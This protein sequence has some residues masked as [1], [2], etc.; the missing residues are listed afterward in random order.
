MSSF[1]Y[2]QSPP[3]RRPLFTSPLPS[4]RAWGFPAWSQTALNKW[5]LELTLIL[6]LT[7]TSNVL[8]LTLILVLTLT[9]NVRFEFT[10][11]VY[12]ETSTTRT[13]LAERTAYGGISIRVEIRLTYS[14]V[15]KAEHRHVEKR[16]RQTRQSHAVPDVGLPAPVQRHELVQ[17]ATNAGAS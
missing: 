8:E 1:P 2:C 12:E 4:A 6:V 11:N 14:D 13:Q 9:S 15:V 10:F 3:P 7:L 17:Q 16:Q 5:T